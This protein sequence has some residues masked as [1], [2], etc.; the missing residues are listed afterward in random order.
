[1]TLQLL[2]DSA[3]RD[4]EADLAAECF[5]HLKQIF[6]RL[7]NVMAKQFHYAVDL[8]LKEKGESKSTVQIRRCRIRSSGKIWIAGN[9]VDPCWLLWISKT[10]GQALAFGE[11]YY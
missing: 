7:N 5:N 11:G 8:A 6:I 2:D 9:V 1:M 4:E 3:S 10:S